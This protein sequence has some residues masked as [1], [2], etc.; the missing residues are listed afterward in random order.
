[1][2]VWMVRVT[3]AVWMVRRFL[4]WPRIAGVVDAYDAMITPRPYAFGAR[5]SHEAAQELIDAKGRLFQSAL[6]EQ[7]I[8]AIGLFPT[9]TLVEM[10]TGEVGIVTRQNNTRRLKPEVVLVLDEDKNT[11]EQLGIVDLSNQDIAKECERWIVREL[12]PGTY[13]VDSEEYFHLMTTDNG[14]IMGVVELAD[15][16]ALLDRHGSASFNDLQEVFFQ[17]HG[18]LGAP[19]GRMGAAGRQAFLRRA[20]GRQQPWRT[21][22]GHRKAG[23]SVS[24]APLPF[25]S[26]RCPWKSPPALPR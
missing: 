6:V 24:R 18:K 3:P 16:D 13:G 9:G 17:T 20:Q 23:A 1:M 11:K 22:A 7:F 14:S 4:Y 5:T 12:L 8:Q 2:N 25:W 26:P 19:Q 10:N 15:A 21:G